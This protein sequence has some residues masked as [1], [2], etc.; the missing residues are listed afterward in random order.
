MVADRRDATQN[1]FQSATK[2]ALGETWTHIPSTRLMLRQHALA[3]R[4]TSAANTDASSNAEDDEGG[5][6]SRESPN[7]GVER[8]A[9]SSYTAEILASSVRVRW[10]CFENW[11]VTCVPFPKCRFVREKETLCPVDEFGALRRQINIV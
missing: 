8:G 1:S 2:P 4:A 7:S 11:F 5:G 6:L 3:A 9:V 10:Q